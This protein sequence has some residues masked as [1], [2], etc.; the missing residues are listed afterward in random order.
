MLAHIALDARKRAKQDP[1]GIALYQKDTITGAYL[2]LG[3]F[4]GLGGYHTGYLQFPISTPER[5]SH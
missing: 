1:L 2:A 3:V 4:V 5:V